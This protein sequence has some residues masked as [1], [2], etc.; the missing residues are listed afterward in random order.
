MEVDILDNKLKEA[1]IENLNFRLFYSSLFPSPPP[2][3]HDQFTDLL[4]DISGW[5]TVRK[6]HLKDHFVN[7][8]FPGRDW[9]PADDPD[10]PLFSSLS[11]SGWVQAC[12]EISAGVLYTF[13][14]VPWQ[15]VGLMTFA[16]I[17]KSTWLAMYKSVCPSGTR[18]IRTNLWPSFSAVWI[19]LWNVLKC[20]TCFLD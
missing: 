14:K 17:L 9:I 16:C 4:T 10:P 13:T 12:G 20:N 6:W 18:L 2:K 3:Y 11:C 5:P 15:K 7:S 19:F 1:K 8:F